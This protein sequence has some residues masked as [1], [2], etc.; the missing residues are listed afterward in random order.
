MLCGR[1][2][3]LKFRAES[4]QFQTRL[5]PVALKGLVVSP[6]G[7]PLPGVSV[8]CASGEPAE[9]QFEKGTL[10]PRGPRNKV[11]LTD[12]EGK[13][14]ISSP[15]EYATIV[16]AAG[17]NGFGFA[18]IEQVRTNG[19]LVFKE[20]GRIEGTLKIAGVPAANHELVFSLLKPVIE[21]DFNEY[22]T[23]TD[24]QG[25]FAIEHVPAG[26]GSLFRLAKLSPS[27]WSYSQRIPVTVDPGK[28]TQVTLGDSGAVLEGRVRF[29]T[30]PLDAEDYAISGRLS[31]EA[32]KVQEFG[33]FDLAQSSIASPE[34]KQRMPRRDY[35]SAVVNTDGSIQFDSVPPGT[36]TLE[37]T[38]RNNHGH[39][40]TSPYVMR[41]Q[42]TI[43]VPEMAT[44]YFPIAIGEI[45]LKP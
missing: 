38:A 22:K 13:F 41:S 34:W 42:Q 21:M 25:H 6:E 39:P 20:F 12:A 18:P 5:I 24:D 23:E 26:E 29:E 17:T 35:F 15:P 45:I 8:T 43:E 30:P 3:F 37:V 7:T 31:S 16:V 4:S 2:P 36:Y 10:H 40:W 14:N 33:S 11:V 19:F 44:P 32:L 9:I 1:N 27:G 28:T